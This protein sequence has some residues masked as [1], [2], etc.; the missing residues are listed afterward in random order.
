MTVG[1]SGFGLVEDDERP[2]C[3]AAPAQ[4]PALSPI[5]YPRSRWGQKLQKLQRGSR[6]A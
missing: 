3:P 5:L 1:L 2:V 4:G 6:Y